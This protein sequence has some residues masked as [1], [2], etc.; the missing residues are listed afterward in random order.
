[1]KWSAKVR[2]DVVDVV[3]RTSTVSAAWGGA[4]ALTALSEVTRKRARTWPNWIVLVGPR[5]LPLMVTHVPP[6]V[7]PDAGE[8]PKITG[9]GGLPRLLA[10]DAAPN[11]AGPVAAAPEEV[12]SE[13]PF[14]AP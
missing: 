9:T 5:P 6:D 11:A 4:C 10:D 14:G 3:T 2:G 13:D 1:M 7:G 12:T 8:M